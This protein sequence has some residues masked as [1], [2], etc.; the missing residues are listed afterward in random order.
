MIII[1]LND[2]NE[3]EED[4]LP[5]FFVAD[6]PELVN[7]KIDLGSST[8]VEQAFSIFTTPQAFDEEG[9]PIRLTFETDGPFVL[10]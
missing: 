2:T 1:V 6:L 9:D 5:P 7:L 3:F 8:A 10:D 4:N